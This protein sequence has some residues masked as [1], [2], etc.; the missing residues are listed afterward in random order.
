MSCT[1]LSGLTFSGTVTT[2][3]NGKEWVTNYGDGHSSKAIP[4]PTGVMGFS[5]CYSR[6]GNTLTIKT[7]SP[8]GDFTNTLTDVN[9]KITGTL[10][11]FGAVSQVNGTAGKFL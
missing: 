5:S 7:S 4:F 11:S 6:S 3:V 1:P 9:G 8:M 10:S 2:T